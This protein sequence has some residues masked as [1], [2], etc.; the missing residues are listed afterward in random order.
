MA[1]VRLVFFF[2]F[3]SFFFNGTCTEYS[4]FKHHN[5]NFKS[6][7]LTVGEICFKTRDIFNPET[8]PIVPEKC[9]SLAF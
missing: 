7:F 5:I 3:F 8:I 4:G 9:A 6:S 2:F 1:N